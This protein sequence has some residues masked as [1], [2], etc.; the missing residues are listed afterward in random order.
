MFKRSQHVGQFCFYG[1]TD[2][3]LGSIFTQNSLPNYNFVTF[4]RHY[5]ARHINKKRERKQRGRER[6]RRTLQHNRLNY[7]IQSLH[8]G[9]QP[10]GS[11]VTGEQTKCWHMLSKK[12]DWFQTG[13]NIYQY[14]A[15]SC[16]QQMLD[17]PLCACLEPNSVI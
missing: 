13:R 11:S 14:H 6:Q 2:G 9:M 5:G 4:V 1:N 8:V 7:R 15:T 3:S 12:F 10:P 17:P 16:I